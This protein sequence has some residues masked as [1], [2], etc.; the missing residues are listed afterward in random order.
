MTRLNIVFNSFGFAGFVGK[1]AARF[2]TVALTFGGL[3]L[4]GCASG[5]TNQAQFS[6]APQVHPDNIYVYA[7]GLDPAQVKLDSGGV[8]KK[9]MSQPGDAEQIEAATGVRESAANA[10]VQKLQSMGLRAIR[11][12][13][14]PPADQNVLIVQG[15]FAKV[16]EG[17]RRRR[18]VIGLG[19][20]KSEIGATV[21][22]LYKPAGGAPLVVQGFDASADSGKMPGIAETAGVG[23]A[24]GHVAT[25]AAVGTS[26]KGYSEVKHA[27]LAA[28]AKKLGDSVAKQVAQV[29]VTQGW[30]AADRIK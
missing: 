6:A 29:G 28:V 8:V 18:V 14:P 30:M 17:N 11:S 13:V 2:A 1:K 20:G 23:A 4:G 21:Q 25:S 19:A 5:I 10:I 7:F 22:V 24:A 3:L 15:S 9:L 12:D 27:T 26:L 16:D